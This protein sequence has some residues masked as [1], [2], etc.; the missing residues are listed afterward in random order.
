M[1]EHSGTPQDDLGPEAK[2]ARFVGVNLELFRAHTSQLEYIA[3]SHVF[4]KTEWCQIPGIQGEVLASSQK[5]AFIE[6]E[7]PSL[8]G[9]QPFWMDILTVNQRNQAEVISVVDIIPQ[10]FR[11]ALKTLAIR[12]DDGIYTCCR[13]A[14][15]KLDWQN[16]SQAWQDHTE[17]HRDDLRDE[18]YL[19]RLWTFQECLFSRE[20]QFVVCRRGEY[21]YP[22]YS[23]ST[24][25]LRPLESH[26][27]G[28]GGV[29]E[30]FY[31]NRVDVQRIME[32]LW[33]LWHCFWS[34]SDLGPTIDEFSHAYIHCKTITRPRPRRR[35]ESED[36]HTGLFR[37]ATL[38]SHRVASKPRDYIFAIMPQFP[39]YNYPSSAKDMTFSQIFLDLYDQ[40]ANTGHQFTPRITASMIESITVEV[41]DALLPSEHQPEPE[42]LGDFLKLLGQ[43]LSVDPPAGS[44]YIHVT[45][46]VLVTEI[47]DVSR[48]NFLEIIRSSMEYSEDLWRFSHRGGELSTFG[49][50][51]Q[52]SWELDVMDA[53]TLGWVPDA[54]S[55]FGDAL[56]M[57]EEKSQTT[58]MTGPRLIFREGPIGE[59]HDLT[60]IEED[61][62]MEHV[63]ILQQSRKILDHMWCASDRMTKDP[64][65]ESDF[66]IFVSTPRFKWPKPLLQTMLL[67]AAMVNCQIGL[68]AAR[69]VH[70]RFVPVLIAYGKDTKVLGLLARHARPSKLGEIKEMYSAGHHPQGKS[71]GKDLVLIDPVVSAGP[72]GIVPDFLYVD[73]TSRQFET[74]M[75][76]LYGGLIKIIGPGKVAIPYISPEVLTSQRQ[77][78]PKD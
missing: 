46:N 16:L 53:A 75:K 55:S 15:G 44:S 8:V 77:N 19:Q 20:I 28:D 70:K 49:N 64:A 5:A 66:K 26:S 17:Q 1:S 76:T 30:R 43:R 27:N 7:L 14:L 59:D 2:F 38:T 24:D 54:G 34:S 37:M 60:R 18:S 12:E 33:V 65:Q 68:S 36:I 35:T 10:I 63:T 40:A 78:N 32:S 47:T 57:T 11:D 23:S 62:S 39:W 42:C 71:I 56:L 41:N 51:P 6:N 25:E 22:P 73:Q 61:R 4:G 58:I 3:V 29:A 72:L 50:F 9:D 52:I 48:N 67:L 31:K 13:T 21:I 69:W 45:T 74:R